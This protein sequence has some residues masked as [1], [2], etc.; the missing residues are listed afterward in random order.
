MNRRKKISF[1]A[2]KWLLLFGLLVGCTP[3]TE[4]SEPPPSVE[5]KTSTPSPAPLPIQVTA[6]TP[7]CD[8]I[9]ARNQNLSLAIAAVNQS[10]LQPGEEFSFNTVV[11][12]RTEEKGYQEAL[13]YDEHGEKQKTVGGGV[14][15]VAT[16]IYMAAL[17]GGF[18]VTERHSHS[19]QVPYADSDH[20]ATVSFGGYD[21]RF[22]NNRDKPITITA[23]ADETAVTVI[24]SE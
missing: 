20:D 6:T 23:S 24:L 12:D 18:E 15:Q 16:T 3:Q 8:N 2:V 11:G 13:G 17:E 22:V 7:I 21:F 5:K 1:Y 10:I 14:C 9:P 19:H 4:Q